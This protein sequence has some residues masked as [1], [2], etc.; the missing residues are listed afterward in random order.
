MTQQLSE[1]EVIDAYRDKQS[2]TEN[3]IVH[4]EAQRTK[5]HRARLVSGSLFLLLIAFG[6]SLPIQDQIHSAAL[7]VIGLF[8]LGLVIKHRAL[9]V[10]LARSISIAE[11]CQQGIHRIQRQWSDIQTRNI[12][13]RESLSA[14]WTDL[15]MDGPRSLMQLFS[16]SRSILADQTLRRWLSKPD[17]IDKIVARQ[18]SQQS[19]LNNTEWLQDTLLLSKNIQDSILKLKQMALNIPL[20]AGKT[21]SVALPAWNIVSAGMILAI[22]NDHLNSLLFFSIPAVNIV[23]LL[24]SRKAF[25][26]TLAQI[27]ID[28]PS[29]RSLTA[30]SEQFERH[31]I[32]DPALKGLRQKLLNPSGL[33]ESTS[34]SSYLKK[35]SALMHLSELRYNGLAYLFAQTFLAWDLHILLRIKRWKFQ[36]GHTLPSTLK[37]IG[38]Y[39][40][41]ASLALLSY[42]N[43]SWTLPSLESGSKATLNVRGAGHPLQGSHKSIKNDFELET[44]KP[45][46]VITGAHMSGKTTFLR[47]IGLNCVLAMAGSVANVKSMQVSK[48]KILTSIHVR[49]SLLDGVS[50]FMSELAQIKHIVDASAEYADQ[51]DVSVLFLIDEIMRGANNRERRKASL[52]ILGTLKGNQTLGIF[53]TNDIDIAEDADRIAGIQNAHF[54]ERI[55][56]GKIFDLEYDYRLKPG[57][58]R[59]T[60]AM[61]YLAKLGITDTV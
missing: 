6:N 50:L 1:R 35:L 28:T 14:L 15:D 51:K 38:N 56:E 31:E 16:S 41:I 55:V 11:H 61:K 60:N 59:T 13:C 23:L 20:K 12:Q 42:E 57:I 37:T 22:V 9:K 44:D 4:Q 36:Y 3:L 26:N 48:M 25:T 2:E 54:D 8:F 47:T 10:A 18:N 34:A 24:A 45:I 53:T 30:L 29:L 58:V 17:S 21:E 32:N 52:E 5:F 40:A 19:L 49:D 39:E 33:N 43:P 46:A 7:I 27:P